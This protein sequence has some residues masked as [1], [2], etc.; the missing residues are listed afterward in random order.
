[1]SVPQ[2]LRILY[3]RSAADKLNTLESLWTS[4]EAAYWRPEAVTPLREFAHR[5]AGSGGS[6]GF[7]KLGDTARELELNLTDLGESTVAPADARKIY[8][9]L[10]EELKTL[11]DEAID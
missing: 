3:I 6:Y 10:R 8:E 5:L 2:D 9:T 11:T 1:M 7:R 4:A